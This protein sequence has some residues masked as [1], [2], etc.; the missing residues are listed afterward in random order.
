MNDGTEDHRAI[1]YND[2]KTLF[3]FVANLIQHIT[4]FALFDCKE[5][6]RRINHIK[7]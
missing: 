4:G 3:V 2:E 7:K 6:A 5:I 1:I